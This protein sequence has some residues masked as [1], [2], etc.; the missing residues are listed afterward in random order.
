[1]ERMHI[2]EVRIVH[3][4]GAKVTAKMRVTSERCVLRTPELSMECA[5]TI[6]RAAYCGPRQLRDCLLRYLDPA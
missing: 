6:G 4:S 3:V 2:G 5:V 1:M